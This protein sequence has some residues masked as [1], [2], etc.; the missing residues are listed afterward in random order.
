MQV[1]IETTSGL[2]RRLTVGVPAERVENEVN[3][4]LQKAAKNVR[5]DG[6]RPGKVP[7][8]VI[9]QRYG[10]GVRQEVLG[11]VM[12]QTFYEAVTQENLRPAGQPSIEPK[13]LEEGK[14]L[15]FVATFEIFPEIELA[16]M[17]GFQVE[18]PAAEVTDTDI[19]DMIEIFRKQQ[20]G[21]EVVERAAAD[22]DQVKLDYAGTRDGEAF[23]G[24]SAEGA[25]LE[26]GSGRMI[27]GFE[28][29]IVGMT[30]GA[31]KTL[32][33]SFPE[34]YH[35]EELKGAAVEFKITLHSVS[36][37]VMAPMDDELF[38]KYGVEGGGEE[39]FRKEIAENMQRELASAIKAKVK[40]QVM[41]AIVSA[42]ESQE[43]PRALID[44]EIG[45]MR[46]QMFQQ[47]GGAGAENMDLESMLPAEMFQDQAERRVKLGLLLN[48][49][50]SSVELKADAD[51][52]REAIEEI[53]STYQDPDEVVQW[54][55]SNE[56]Q[57]S[58]VESMVLEDQAVQQLLEQATITDQA[59]TYQEAIAKAQENQS[60]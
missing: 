24:G 57:L 27:P 58:G 5:L 37:Q 54:Y 10:A 14:D 55:Y 40:Q 59:C 36:E 47:F 52:V 56:E 29:G 25:D 53:A 31:E 6:F 32:A 34:D 44:Q 3:I 28:D 30:A 12:S 49:Y 23:E 43:V 13:S 50:I 41:D 16:D 4:R 22:G 33:L 45:N 1:F 60:V 15:E 38:Q 21:L 17:A 8:R 20:G 48:E 2:E 7:M 51:K 39:Q 42:N 18:R 19:D 11:E 9:R 26:L 35:S 46:K